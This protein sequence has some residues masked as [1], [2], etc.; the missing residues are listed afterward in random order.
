[1]EK[2]DNGKPTSAQ[3][4]EYRFIHQRIPQHLGRQRFLMPIL[5]LAFEFA[6]IIL[7]AVFANYQSDEIMRTNEDVFRIYP[8]MYYFY[9]NRTSYSSYQYWHILLTS[10]DAPTSVPRHTRVRH[11]GHWLH[12]D[13]FEALRLW[14]SWIQLAFIGV[15]HAMVVVGSGLD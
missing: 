10:L 13:I 12:N 5:L 1:M 6:F 14:K 2:A 9:W 11:I 7:F 8:S 4:A 3:S 15:C